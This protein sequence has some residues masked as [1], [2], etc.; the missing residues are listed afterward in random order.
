MIKQASRT[1]MNATMKFSSFNTNGS[2]LDNTDGN[3][4]GL[5]VSKQESQYQTADQYYSNLNTKSIKS[6]LKSS[7]STS[8]FSKSS[9]CTTNRPSNR[10]LF[11]KY[12]SSLSQVSIQGESTAKANSKT[13]SKASIFDRNSSKS[14]KGKK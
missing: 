10:K 5:T 3:K 13:K 9:Y 7:C 6:L 8:A 4:S 1:P 11:I 2:L 14:S 12:P